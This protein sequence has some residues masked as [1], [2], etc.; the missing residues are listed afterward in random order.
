MRIGMGAVCTAGSITDS[1]CG[2][3][4]KNGGPM[5][6]LVFGTPCTMCPSR[7]PIAAPALPSGSTSPGLPVGYDPNSGT[8]DPG[9][10]PSGSTIANPYA[11]NYPS[12]PGYGTNLDSRGCDLSAQSWF[13]TSTWCQSRWIEAGLGGLALI[14]FVGLMIRR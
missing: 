8:I 12:V 4:T 6:D 7:Q 5:F 13:D 1:M 2:W 11:P 10:N 3:S 14:L 9:I